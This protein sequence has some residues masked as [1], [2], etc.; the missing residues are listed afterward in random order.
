MKI[1]EHKRKGI[2]KNDDEMKNSIKKAIDHAEFPQGLKSYNSVSDED[3]DEF[4]S[5]PINTP[6]PK[7]KSKTQ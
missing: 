3:S 7:K 2:Y 1:I 4:G 6:T 5:S